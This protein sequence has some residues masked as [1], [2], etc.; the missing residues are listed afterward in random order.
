MTRARGWPPLNKAKFIRAVQ[1]AWKAADAVEQGVIPIETGKKIHVVDDAEQVVHVV[2][3][4]AHPLNAAMSTVMR[5]FTVRRRS[6]AGMRFLALCDA[7]A[8]LGPDFV[9]DGGRQI[10]NSVI[11]AAAIVPLP[12]KRGRFNMGALERAARKLEGN[13]E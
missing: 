9:R 2:Q 3:L 7:V 11:E 4:T 5:P 10:R 12:K 8:K 1:A 13:S 6:A